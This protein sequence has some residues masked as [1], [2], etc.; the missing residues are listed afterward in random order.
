M[1]RLVCV[2]SAFKK[3]VLPVP[4]CEGVIAQDIS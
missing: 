2:A 4:A 1:E 3:V